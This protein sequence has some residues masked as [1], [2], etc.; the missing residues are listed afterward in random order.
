MSALLQYFLMSSLLGCQTDAKEEILPSSINF[1][2][3][4]PKL[5]GS[6]MALDKPIATFLNIQRNNWSIKSWSV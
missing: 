2:N 4:A 3:A 6:F 5:Y 1:I